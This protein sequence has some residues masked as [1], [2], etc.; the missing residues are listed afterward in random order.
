MDKGLRIFSEILQYL[1]LGTNDISQ[2]FSWIYKAWF[3]KVRRL[4]KR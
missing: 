1:A 2:T 3:Q 4:R